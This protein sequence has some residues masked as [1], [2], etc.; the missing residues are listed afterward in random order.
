VNLGYSGLNVVLSQ[1]SGDENCL[2]TRYKKLSAGLA[3][4]LFS[5]AQM[6]VDA[7]TL[8]QPTNQ[9]LS[10]NYIPYSFHRLA[11][12]S[13]VSGRELTQEGGNL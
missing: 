9:D 6:S 5:Y 7:D 12:C 2:E 4:N 13:I 3:R 10:A 1:A 8:E 11:T